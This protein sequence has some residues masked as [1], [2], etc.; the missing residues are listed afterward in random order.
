MPDGFNLIQN[1]MTHMY[2]ADIDARWFQSDTDYDACADDPCDHNCENMEGRAFVCTCRQ[3]FILAEDKTTCLGKKSPLQS[4]YS[5]LSVEVRNY[6]RGKGFSIS[7]Y[8]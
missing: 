2:N 1:M 3:G 6:K 4:V 8:Y 5:L 7:G